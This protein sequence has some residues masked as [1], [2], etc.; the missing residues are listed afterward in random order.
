VVRSVEEFLDCG[1]LQGGFARNP[2]RRLHPYPED[3]L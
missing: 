2:L 3:P 1:R